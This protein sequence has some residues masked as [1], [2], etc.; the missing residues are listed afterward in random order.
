MFS[1]GQPLTRT[2]PTVVGQHIPGNYQPYGPILEI[3]YGQP[4]ASQPSMVTPN[5][6]INTMWNPSFTQQSLQPTP[7]MT[8]NQPTQ[9]LR[10]FFYTQ[11]QQPFQ[12]AHQITQ[13]ASM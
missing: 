3:S 7:K 5:P 4:Y 9:S 2:Y 12:G 8:Y 1:G 11:V 10:Q 13:R 6:G